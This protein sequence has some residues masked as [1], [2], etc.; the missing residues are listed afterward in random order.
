MESDDYALSVADGSYA[1]YRMRAARCRRAHKINEVALLVTTASIPL[2]SVV[3]PDYTAITAVL[4]GLAVLCAGFRG[5]FR[6][7]ENFLRFSAAREAVDAER[8]GYHTRSVPYQ[9]VTTRAQALVAA[10]TRIEQEE[11]KG[12]LSTVAS[13]P[14]GRPQPTRAAAINWRIYIYHSRTSAADPPQHAVC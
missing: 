1:W 13:Q 7:H 3:A 5:I 4:G 2:T 8:R 9:D 10:V 12:W 6:W 14:P 11:M